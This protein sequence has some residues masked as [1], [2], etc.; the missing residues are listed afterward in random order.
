M[1]AAQPHRARLASALLMGSV[2]SKMPYEMAPG[3]AGTTG[4]TRLSQASQAGASESWPTRFGMRS[5][6]LRRAVFLIGSGELA[7]VGGGFNQTKLRQC[8]SAGFP[9]AP[10]L[11]RSSRQQ[12]KVVRRPVPGDTMAAPR[13]TAPDTLHRDPGLQ[14]LQLTRRQLGER[15]SKAPQR[16]RQQGIHALYFISSRR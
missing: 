9:L 2:S 10:R 14:R 3:A 1:A 7:E 15:P 6:R 4:D 12:A 13:P 5:A 8:A 11:R 16:E